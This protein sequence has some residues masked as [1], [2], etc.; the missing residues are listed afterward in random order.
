MKKIILLIG[1][2][3]FLFS[4]SCFSQSGNW[5]NY[6]DDSW[7]NENETFFFLQ[8]PAQLAGLAKQVNSGNTFAD[9]TIVLESIIDLG[10]HY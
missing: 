2:I 8:T 5:S 7:Y 4:G 3:T 9:K 6:A 10:A 1:L